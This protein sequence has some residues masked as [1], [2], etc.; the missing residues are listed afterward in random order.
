MTDTMNDEVGFENVEE[1]ADPSSTRHFNVDYDFE[2]VDDLPTR[3]YMGGNGQGRPSILE[4]QLDKVVADDSLHNKWVRIGK[5]GKPT[6]ATAAKNVL[7]Q[8][9]GRTESVH[10]FA[11]ATRRLP[12][13][14]QAA[15]LFVKYNPGSVIPG[16]YD[17]HVNN[18]KERAVRLEQARKAREAEKAS[19]AAST[20]ETADAATATTDEAASTHPA[21]GKGKASK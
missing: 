17:A 1:Q 10:G 6:A 8:R 9:H 21:K 3:S 15:G 16:A 7:Q 12:P 18:E 2:V 14:N 5:Y 13:D 11:F 20:D 19:T 4:A